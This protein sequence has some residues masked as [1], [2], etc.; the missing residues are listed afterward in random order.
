[1]ENRHGQHTFDLPTVANDMGVTPV[2]LTNQLYDLKLKGEITY[3]MKDMAY[4][5]RILEVPTY[6]LSLSADITKWLS[7]VE[8]CKVRK[9]DAM[10]NAAY[11]AVNLCDKMNGCSSADHTSCLQRI[12]LD[13]FAGIDNIDF[14]KKIDQSRFLLISVSS[15]VEKN[16]FN[17]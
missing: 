5:Y 3:E 6:L 10:F 8:S 4:C 13:Y 1:S 2:E 15:F 7:E 9:M 16:T 11:F 17:Q 12:I 14:C